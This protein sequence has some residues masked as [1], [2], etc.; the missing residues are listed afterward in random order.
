MLRSC[1]HVSEWLYRRVR[2]KKAMEEWERDSFRI[3]IIKFPQLAIDEQVRY[4]R[5]ELR[6]KPAESLRPT[7]FQLMTWHICEWRHQFRCANKVRKFFFALRIFINLAYVML[8]NVQCTWWRWARWEKSADQSYR[9]RSRVTISINFK[10]HRFES[11]KRSVVTFLR[12]IKVT[13]WQ[14]SSSSLNY[15]NWNYILIIIYTELVPQSTLTI[16]SFF[17]NYK[18]I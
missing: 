14:S 9:N 1:R 15:Q 17:I 10:L 11:I 18:I 5:Y 12:I 2:E 7:H 8:Y 3:T 16:N 13:Q 6:K 4:I